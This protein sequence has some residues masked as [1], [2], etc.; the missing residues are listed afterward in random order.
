[1]KPGKKGLALDP[2]AFQLQVQHAEEVHAKAQQ[3]AGQAPPSVS[4]S[5]AAGSPAQA[6][7]TAAPAAA[8][9]AGASASASGAA[10]G[11]A[12]TPSAAAPAAANAPSSSGQDF[13]D[14][15]G[16]R[17]VSVSTYQNRVLVDL[18]EWYQKDG[19]TLPGKKGI[20]LPPADW[21]AV[22]AAADAISAAAAAKN[23][24]YVQELSGSRRVTISEFKSKMYVAVREY[25]EK[26]GQMLPGQKGLNMAVDAWQRLLAGRH[27][28][29]AAVARLGG[30]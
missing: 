14:L 12:A 13:I 10:A 8:A 17:R 11:S 30:E 23:T 29:D 3:L 25:Y 4:S 16:D 22:C 2:Q 24:S 6:P 5:K 7:P 26:N 18:R 28:I 21:Q 27:V 20:S 9:A 19:A 1:M 15:G